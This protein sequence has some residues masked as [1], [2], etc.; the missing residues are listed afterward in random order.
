MTLAEGTVLDGKYEVRRL[1][2]TGAWGAVYEGA[3]TRINRQ[4]AIK[5]LHSDVS[6]NEDAR[7]RFE[8]EAQVG[9]RAKS[10]HIL[11]ILDLGSLP[12]GGSYVVMEYLDGESLEKR[13]RALGRLP[14]PAAVR[15]ARQVAVGLCAAH[16][17]GVIHRDLK[18]ENVYLLKSKAGRRDFV[19]L[20]DFGVA[21]FVDQGMKM[22]QAGAFLG[23]PLYAAPE[24]IHGSQSVGPSAD[25]YAVGVMLYQMLTG[26]VPYMAS[27]LAELLTKVTVGTAQ[28]P[29]VLN[30]S[31]DLELEA[32][33]M[34]AMAR[35][36]EA[37]FQTGE[38]LIT[39]VDDWAA[40]HRVSLAPELVDHPSRESDPPFSD[41]GAD[42]GL[43]PESPL[44]GALPVAG[45]SRA[46]SAT[47]DP[48]RV[49]K[50]SLVP[51]LAVFALLGVLGLAVGTT[52]WFWL[53]ATP[54]REPATSVPSVAVSE[55]ALTAS[56]STSDS[57]AEV[58]DVSV[59]TSALPDAG[60][61]GGGP[62]PNA[63]GPLPPRS[64]PSV[65]TVRGATPS[66]A[67][68]GPSATPST[69]PPTV[70]APAPPPPP[71][72]APRRSPE[73]VLQDSLGY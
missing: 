27:T 66:T 29:T 44:E 61:T 3:N 1:L 32:I 50:R 37:R 17:A 20:I 2:A 62:P 16:A 70:A 41:I 26:T 57:S 64:A 51:V 40:R 12:D 71:R 49:P 22:T 63:R 18:P 30:P 25:I 11:E 68:A 21:R 9:G 73:E 42:A 59:V 48:V 35:E 36:P 46:W 65:V 6:A 43:A 28:R 5:V 23:T 14:V 72:P 24:Q 58:P 67:S 60:R 52:G 31:L 7:V 55:V 38:A 10:D 15:I 69:A 13:L 53:T 39:A 56:D 47:D 8:R 54:P 45:T 33:V 19:K 4:V 34:R